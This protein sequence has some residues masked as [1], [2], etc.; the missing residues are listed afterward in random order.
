MYA[1]INRFPLDVPVADLRETVK[2][3]FPPVFDALPGFLDFY[4][5]EAGPQEAIAIMLWESAE[6]AQG[7]GHAIGPTIFAQYIAPHLAGEQDRVI[8]EVLVAHPASSPPTG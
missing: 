8:G 3:E 2:R 1:V 7:G 6:A 5:V 4:L